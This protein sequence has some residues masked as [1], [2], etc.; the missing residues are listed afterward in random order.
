MDNTLRIIS[1]II[2]NRAFADFIDITDRTIY[3]ID[4]AG[5]EDSLYG[6]NYSKITDEQL[7]WLIANPSLGEHESIADWALATIPAAGAWVHD[8]FQW[9]SF[10]D[11]NDIQACQL[12]AIQEV[13]KLADA[14]HI[15]IPNAPETSALVIKWLQKSREK[16]AQ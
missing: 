8:R 10:N 1:T 15:L 5:E 11:P 13:L 9:W 3:C 16:N 12:E 4:C 2:N 14:N 7:D 6:Y